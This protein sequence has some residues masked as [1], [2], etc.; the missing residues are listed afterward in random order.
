M[1][2]Q[3]S[4]L[5][6]ILIALGAGVL[7]LPT[8][9]QAAFP[10]PHYSEVTPTSKMAID[11]VWLLTVNNKRIKIKKGRAY[12]LDGWQQIFAPYIDPEKVVL[13]DIA[14]LGKGH[15]SGD[16]LPLSSAFNAN[17]QANGDLLFQVG[18]IFYTLTP[19]KLD[20][21]IEYLGLMTQAGLEP[22]DSEYLSNWIIAEKRKRELNEE[23]GDI[24][25]SEADAAQ[26][27]E[28]ELDQ[29][30]TEDD[31]SEPTDE[32]PPLWTDDPEYVED[33]D[34]EYIDE[35]PPEYEEEPEYVEDEE[36]EADEV[37]SDATELEPQ[38]KK[39]RRIKAK[40]HGKVKP[41][42]IACTGKNIYL[43]DGACFSCPAN[44]KRASLTRKMSHPQACQKRG[45]PK[46]NY[47]KATYGG[48]ARPIKGCPGGNNYRSDGGCYTCPNGYKRASVTR[49]M[50]HPKACQ[51]RG[52]PKH[53]Y[54]RAKLAYKLDLN[55]L[56]C[57]K[58]QFK[59]EG[60]CKSCPTGTT[61]VH[62]WGLDSGFCAYIK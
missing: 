31:A 9:S 37:E 35:L 41:K 39:L 2:S 18:L 4:R 53:Q 55:P 50:N 44:Y 26:E 57:P 16:D 59:H 32:E 52:L 5:F 25:S 1:F 3:I 12:A 45:L 8:T 40:I 17:I 46:H 21:P 20:E 43:S 54:G 14:Y 15:F 6:L 7:M 28:D 11:G 13:K 36:P 29:D 10:L 42:K 58:G 49:K 56:S 47:K 33:E 48:K 27:Q 62:A 30:V 60:Y 51:S 61:R 22:D 23:L 34:P 38:P 24:A 19:V